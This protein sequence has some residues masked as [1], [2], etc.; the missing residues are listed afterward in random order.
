MSTTR[1]PAKELRPLVLAAEQLTDVDQ[2]RALENIRAKAQDLED[3]LLLDMTIDT[4]QGEIARQ[5]GISPQ[6]VS[7]RVKHARRRRAGGGS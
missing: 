3:Q 7:F 2:L 1:V 4:S 5:L 6:A